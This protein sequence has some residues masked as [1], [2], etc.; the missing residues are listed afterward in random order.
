M[1]NHIGFTSSIPVEII[2]AAGLIPC[3]LNNLF[4]GDPHPGLLIEQAEASG[5]PATS[6][7]W[8]KGIYAT[9]KKHGIT[10][11]V[12]VVSGDCSST[13]ALAEVLE[14]EG[15]EIVPFAFPLNRNPKAMREALE[16][17]RRYFRVSRDE[18]KNCKRNLDAIRRQLEELDRLTWEEGR[19]SGEE[20][21]RF[22]VSASDFGGNPEHFSH[23]LN[24][25]L[26]EARRRQPKPST[27]RLGI[28]GVPPIISNFYPVIKELGVE[29]VFNEVQRQ[30]SM[31]GAG[32]LGLAGQ[33]LAYTYPYAVSGRITDIKTEIDRRRIDGIIHYVQSFCF[34]QIEDIIIKKELPVPVLTIESDRPAP[35]D[36]RTITRLE[37]FIEILQ[38]RQ[39]S[40]HPHPLF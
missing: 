23:A 38:G 8:I 5:F 15:V 34:R 30:F 28:I 20:N 12:A 33:Y 10:K 16:E 17:F 27:L 21:H 19:V 14:Y 24:T 25:F 22:L 6:C 31:P 32:N 7:A 11:V 40:P 4:I 3:D 39:K 36:G 9:I 29:V 18:V 2:Y 35:V 1:I 37:T 26:H 13:H